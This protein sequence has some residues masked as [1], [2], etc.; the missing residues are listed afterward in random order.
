M[1]TLAGDTTVHSFDALDYVGT[2]PL[3]RDQA[4]SGRLHEPNLMITSIDPITGNDIERFEG[5]PFIVDGNM[6]IYFE[7]EETRQA[8]M[9]LPMDHPVPLPDNPDEDW[10]AEG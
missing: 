9:D 2:D 4:Q 1:S 5:S 10:V 3:A 6:T 8:Y 7:S